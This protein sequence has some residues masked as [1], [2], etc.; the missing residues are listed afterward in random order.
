MK[1]SRRIAVLVAAATLL[2]A[3][4]ARAEEG[5]SRTEYVEQVEPICQANTEAN[6]R[7]LAHAGE[8]ARSKQQRMM[9]R[10]AGQFI[11]ASEAFGRAVDKIAAVPRPPADEPRLLKWIKHLRIVGTDLRK[12]GGALKEG[13]KIRAAHEKIRVERAA[14]ASNNVGFV[15][16]FHYCYLEQSRFT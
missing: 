14:N 3:G 10:A 11:R 5:P 12:I 7:I 2:S 15:F 6:K 9:T 13:D 4:L 16:K 8:R 1:G